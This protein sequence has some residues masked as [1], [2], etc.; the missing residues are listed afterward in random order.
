MGEVPHDGKIAVMQGVT[1]GKVQSHYTQNMRSI[2]VQIMYLVSS[3]CSSG[4]ADRTSSV[5]D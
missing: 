5:V 3:L 1:I 4:L 2:Q